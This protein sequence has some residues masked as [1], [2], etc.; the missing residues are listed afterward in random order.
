MVRVGLVQM[1]PTMGDI[2]GNVKK[3]L[4][5]MEKLEELKVDV[6]IFPEL[7]LTGYPPKDLLLRIDFLEKAE[8][9]LKKIAEL[10]KN[11]DLV[12]V[13]GFPQIDDDVYNAA[14]V[15]GQGRILA[16]YKKRFLP[17]HSAFD[18]HRYF[19]PG[20]DLVVLNSKEGM[21]GVTIC[22]DIWNSPGPLEEYAS[23]GVGCVIN[24]SAS[25]FIDGKISLRKNLISAKAYEHHI[26]IIY[27]NTYGG[28]DELVFDGS[29]FI[30][31]P[32]GA[33]YHELPSFKEETSIVDID[34]KNAKSSFLLDPRERFLRRNFQATTVDIPLKEK[35]S[36][37]F[38]KKP[39]E[40]ER[41]EQLLQ[42]LIT[43]LRDYVRKNGFKK[44]VVGLSGGID[45]SLV[46]AIAALALGPES[47]LGVLM[48]SMYTSQHSI[49]DAQRLAKNLG[50]KT[51]TIPITDVY[52]SYV[53]ALREVFEGRETDV[54]EENIQARIR[55]NYLMAISNK[56]GYLVI[57]TGNKSEY[58][59]GY[60][61]LYGDMVGGYALLKDVYKTDVYKI[62]R[63][64][65][66]REGREIIP[67]RVFEKPPSAEL[68]PGQTDQDKLPPYETLDGILRLLIDEGKTPQEIIS[69]GY[70]EKTVEYVLKLVKNSEYKRYQ[71]AP[72]PK[73]T[74]RLFG[75]D[76]RQPITNKFLY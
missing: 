29:S 20:N 39:C 13:I 36:L 59:T 5:N 70:D 53:E 21:I 75:L 56:F 58:A 61:T 65:N 12:S 45:S 26:W 25:P 10:S 50:I 62:A 30:A 47:V 6:A 38:G 4:E 55:G 15:V 76:W 49:E 57:T 3:I 16:V 1:N 24:I 27:L 52:H 8:K 74:P 66:K 22:E 19:K 64:I 46:A 32:T 71:S 2:E 60:A 43:A 33:I 7:A 44:V 35:S 54:T 41:E 17:N 11:H 14:A 68:R 31:S 42:A 51:L 67:E 73:I 63:Y 40:I 34:L 9:H 72:G 48:P 23:L 37:I 28:Q 69:A 18:E